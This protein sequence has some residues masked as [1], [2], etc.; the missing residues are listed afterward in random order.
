MAKTET[1]RVRRKERKNI[2]NGV[3]HVNASFNNT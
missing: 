2:T 3:A 1:T